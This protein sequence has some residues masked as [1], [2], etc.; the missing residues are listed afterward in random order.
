LTYLLQFSQSATFDKHFNTTK[1]SKPMKSTTPLFTLVLLGVFLSCAP[2]AVE[3]ETAIHTPVIQTEE[4]TYRVDSL[5]FIGWMA[6]DSALHTKRPGIV[7][8]HEWWGH[9]DHTRAQA[10]KLAEA[11]YTAFALDMYGDGKQAAHPDSAMA[12][13]GQALATAGGAGARFDKSVEILKAHSSVDPQKIGAVGY[14]FGGTVA[15]EMARAGKDLDAVVCF[16]GG[17]DT[18]NPAK[19]NVMKSAVL[20]CTGGSDPMIPEESVKAFEAEMES[21]GI[22]HKV[23]RYPEAKHAF[24]NPAADSLGKVFDLPIEYSLHSDTSSWNAAREFLSSEF[25]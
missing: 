9:N 19:S 23:I 13:I 8:I 6:W 11:G 7:V 17:L 2:A 25:K 4:I 22:D 24:T 20:V 5:E 3:Q 18:E 10:R 1:K 16:H 15:L 12:F 14:C 21:A